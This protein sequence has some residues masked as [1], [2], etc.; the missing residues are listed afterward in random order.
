[1]SASPR[2]RARSAR[3]PRCTD[4][5]LNF[6]PDELERRRLDAGAGWHVDDYAQ[7]LPPEP[8]GEPA[9][10]GSF[11]IAQRLMRDYAF[12]DPRS[13]AP[14]TTRPA[15]SPTATCCCRSA[16]ARCASSSAA[17]SATITDETRTVD[18]RAACASGAGATAR[19]PATSSA[20]R[21]T[22]PCG[23]GS[24]TARSSSASTSSRAARRCATRS[25]G[26][27]SGSSAAA[28]RCASPSRACERMGELVELERD[29][30][31][32]HVDVPEDARLTAPSVSGLNSPW[33]QRAAGPA[34]AVPTLNGAMPEG[35]TIH[36]AARR[37]RPL[38]EGRVPEIAHPHPRLRGERWP[39]KLAGRAVTRRRRPRQAP[40][41]ALRGRPRD[42][43]A[44]AHDRAPGAPT[45]TASAGGARA[46]RA[47]LVLRTDA[48]RGR[49]VRRPGARAADRVAHALRPP[50]GDARPR[51][52]R[53]R[54]RRAGVPAPPARR[55][56]RRARS[57]TRCST[58]ARSPGSATCG[59]ARAASPRG[60]DP[61]RAD[62]RG[63]RRRGAGDRA[64]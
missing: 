44:P 31:P 37:I 45:A 21:W 36:Y 11:A 13:C 49:P 53:A 35:D 63:Q 10:G 52:P 33:V 64:R 4:R 48:R 59:S 18:G 9:P 1:M 54:A 29:E 58:S 61:W 8:P 34:A 2:R 56:T 3:S 17:A 50:P 43:L 28:S 25:C 12:A 51:H 32:Q 47:W 23:S 24:T 26:S 40:L 39:D 16:S 42:P 5:P 19:W 27:A 46:R 7:P 55:T 30:P 41:R 6:D 20:G 15:S 62:R 60:I 22:G 57:A 14:S 38:L